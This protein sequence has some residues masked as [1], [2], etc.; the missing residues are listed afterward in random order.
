LLVAASGLAV[1]TGARL[2]GQRLLLPA[3]IWRQAALVEQQ[4]QQQ[5]RRRQPGTP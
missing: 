3:L 4:Q 2:P 5:Q 1:C